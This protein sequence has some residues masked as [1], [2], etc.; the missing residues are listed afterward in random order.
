MN[1]GQKGVSDSLET[2]SNGLIYA[3][4]NEENAINVFDPSNET[5]LTF[6]QFCE[7]TGWVDTSK[8]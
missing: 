3:S 1:N 6:L 5:T 7:S 4:N 2:H 8:R